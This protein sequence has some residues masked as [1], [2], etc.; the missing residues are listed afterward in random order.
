MDELVATWSK[1]DAAVFAAAIPRRVLK[2]LPKWRSLTVRGTT[3]GV[4]FRH[5]LGRAAGAVG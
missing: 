3:P 5:P 4:G 1:A 2:P